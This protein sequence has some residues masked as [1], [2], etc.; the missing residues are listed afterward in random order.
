MFWGAQKPWIGKRVDWSNS[1]SPGLVAYYLMNEGSGDVFD[2]TNNNLSG[3]F[4]NSPS[5]AAGPNG[6]VV[7]FDGSNDRIDVSFFPNLDELS[8]VA[9]VKRGS[10]SGVREYIANLELAGISQHILWFNGV[11]D[12]NITITSNGT[13]TAAS[14]PV[15]GGDWFQVGFTVSSS[16]TTLYLNG[17]STGTPDTTFT[18]TAFDSL[19]LGGRT[20]DNARNLEGLIDHILIWDRAL[21][22]DEV[23]KMYLNR[24]FLVKGPFSELTSYFAPA[25]VTDT[26]FVARRRRMDNGYFL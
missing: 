4:I 18:K 26:V 21:T 22:A 1:I 14:S 10:G 8:I 23:F 5:W 2:L 16:T 11:N 17:R 19:H 15:A 25:V 12:L 20:S 3:S 7:S 9:W 24:Y 6:S 13:V